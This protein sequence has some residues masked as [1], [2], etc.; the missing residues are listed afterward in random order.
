MGDNY[1]GLG[2]PKVSNVS[3]L[4]G[5]TVNSCCDERFG[6]FSF[7]VV[8]FGHIPRIVIAF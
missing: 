4:K 3:H 7:R 8:F 6:L 2:G 5:L 1:G